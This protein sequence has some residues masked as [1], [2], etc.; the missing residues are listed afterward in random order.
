M[1]G[2]INVGGPEGPGM[3]AML[4]FSTNSHWVFAV[5]IIHHSVF[6][7]NFCALHYIQS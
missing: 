1:T 2:K 6:Y 4:Y 3:L 5:I 7:V